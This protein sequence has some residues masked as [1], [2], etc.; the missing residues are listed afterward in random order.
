MLLFAYTDKTGALTFDICLFFHHIDI[1]NKRQARVSENC[2]WRIRHNFEDGIANTFSLY[3]YEKINGEIQ[4]KE[5]EAEIVRHIFRFYL[6]GMGTTKIAK[7]LRQKKI[8]SPKGSVWRHKAILGILKNE[9]Y[10]G[11][12]LLQKCYS[13][14]HLSKL[15]MR[16]NGELP[17]FYVKGSHPAII[18]RADF[19]AVQRIFKE[20]AALSRPV[21]YDYDFKGMVFCGVCGCRYMRKKNHGN[22]IWRCNAYNLD[23]LEAC[24]SKQIPDSILHRLADECDKLI[25]KIFIMSENSVKF[26]FTDNTE[27]TLK[28]ANPSRRDSWTPEMR[29]AARKKALERRR[30]QCPEQ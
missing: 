12:M 11:D 9:K 28:W 17:K 4:V 15:K 23:G 19:D 13:K 27:T 30:V 24:T 2:K 8:P 3:G 29:E 25:K 18:S 16:N 5:C 22:Y 20:Q 10:I 26:I 21:C 1:S 6:S 14:D 7:Y